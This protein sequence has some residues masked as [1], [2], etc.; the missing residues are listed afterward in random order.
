M[1]TAFEKRGFMEKSKNFQ[2][3]YP[4]TT[5]NITGYITQ[6]DIKNKDIL[7][8]GSSCDQAFNS[9]LLGANEVTIFDINERIEEY[10]ELKRKLILQIPREKLVETVIKSRKVPFLEE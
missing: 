7:T 8:L 6:M 5:E 10:Y 4:F 3:V 9:L 2:A 1:I